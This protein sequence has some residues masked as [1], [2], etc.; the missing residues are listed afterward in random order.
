MV[1]T[2]TQTTTKLNSRDEE[3]KFRSS[4]PFFEAYRQTGP[5]RIESGKPE[6]GASV[7]STQGAFRVGSTKLARSLVYFCIGTRVGRLNGA[8]LK[9]WKTSG[10]PSFLKLASPRPKNCTTSIGERLCE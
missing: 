3:R 4:F 2:K 10:K 1:I 5:P 7:G 9:N 6:T 8:L